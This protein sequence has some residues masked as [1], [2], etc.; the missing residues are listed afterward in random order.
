MSFREISEALFLMPQSPPDQHEEPM[1]FYETPL[2]NPSAASL[3]LL[4]GIV[5]IAAIVLSLRISNAEKLTSSAET[6]TNTT[7]ID[8]VLPETQKLIQDDREQKF[9][10]YTPA[11]QK[12]ITETKPIQ[13]TT[14]IPKPSATVPITKKSDRTT[15][16]S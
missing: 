11:Q 5:V 9:T 4:L 13:T 6:I 2:K 10:S 15:K 1:H 7:P 16:T 12:T 14:I 3:S 8:P